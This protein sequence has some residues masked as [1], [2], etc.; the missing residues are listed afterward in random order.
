MQSRSTPGRRWT[1]SEQ[2]FRVPSPTTLMLNITKYQKYPRGNKFKLS[3][4]CLNLL[5]PTLIPHW[6]STSWPIRELHVNTYLSIVVFLRRHATYKMYVWSII[7]IGRKIKEQYQSSVKS[8]KSK[9]DIDLWLLDSKIN[10]IP[11]RVMVN[12]FVN[13]YQYRSNGIGYIM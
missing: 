3:K 9:F 4:F 13:Y 12:T 1:V 6:P 5:T 7:I 10:R 8:S 11:S 2:I